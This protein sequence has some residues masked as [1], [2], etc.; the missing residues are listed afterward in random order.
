MLD[1]KTELEEEKKYKVKVQM[2]VFPPQTDRHS[3]DYFKLASATRATK[4]KKAGEGQTDG[5]AQAFLM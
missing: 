2:R 5:Q 4:G 1:C 3:R